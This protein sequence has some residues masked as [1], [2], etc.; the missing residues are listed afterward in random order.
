MTQLL[1]TFKKAL[2][3]DYLEDKV[4]YRTKNNL[5]VTLY[6]FKTALGIRSI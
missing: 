3:N 6:I 5:H 4:Q 1:Q 2:E